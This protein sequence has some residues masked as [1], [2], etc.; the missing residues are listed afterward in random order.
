[1]KDERWNIRIRSNKY[2]NG[3]EVTH[4]RKGVMERVCEGKLQDA[5][6][7]LPQIL[8]RAVPQPSSP[9]LSWPRGASRAIHRASWIYVVCCILGSR[10]THPLLTFYSLLLTS[11]TTHSF[12][13]PVPRTIQTLLVHVSCLISV[14]SNKHPNHALVWWNILHQNRYALSSS[15]SSTTRVLSLRR[16]SMHVKVYQLIFIYLNKINHFPPFF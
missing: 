3:A 16:S 9:T 13:A 7:S 1:M 12:P 4:D 11:Y 5:S 10:S 14:E 15:L 6:L 2:T 8:A